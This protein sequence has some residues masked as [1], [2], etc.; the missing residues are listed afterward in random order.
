LAFARRDAASGDQVLVIAN[1][2]DKAVAVD[3]AAPAEW[4]ARPARDRLSGDV[5]TAADG[6]IK[7]EMAPKTVRIITPASN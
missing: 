7:L 6:R 5:V 2:E 1:R 4:P 3:L